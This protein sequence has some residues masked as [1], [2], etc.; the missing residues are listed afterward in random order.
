MSG[1]NFIRIA[2]RQKDQVRRD[3][4]F[5]GLMALLI[6][7]FVAAV[8]SSSSSLVTRSRAPAAAPPTIQEMIDTS[9]AGC[10]E[11]TR[12][13]MAEIAASQRRLC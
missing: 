10:D 3:R 13:A 8:G 7:F 4:L 12:P 9:V 6:A 1:R 11:S 2:E 5:A